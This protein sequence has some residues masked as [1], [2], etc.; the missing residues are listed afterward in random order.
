MIEQIHEYMKNIDSVMT[1]T[2]ILY[3][4]AKQL[5]IAEK[6]AYYDGHSNEFLADT[7]DEGL[8]LF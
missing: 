6:L 5:G 2:G 7:I 3:Y 1:E 8:R 4:A